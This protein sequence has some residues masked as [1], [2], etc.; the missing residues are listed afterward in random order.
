MANGKPSPPRSGLIRTSGLSNVTVSV[1]PV[2]ADQAGAWLRD[3]NPQNRSIKKARVRLLEAELRE[4]RY[5]LNGE[6]VIFDENGKLVDGQHR[7]SAIANTGIT[8]DCVIVRG[9]DPR[10]RRTIDQGSIRTISDDLQM[11]GR[12]R[13]LGVGAAARIAHNYLTGAKIGSKVTKSA[14]HDFIDAND[15]LFAAAEMGMGSGI[16]F[17]PRY[18]SATVFLGT[19]APETREQGA[20]FVAGLDTGANFHLGDARLALRE[21]FSR[22]RLHDEKITPDWALSAT[23]RA[24]NAW[25]VNLPMEKLVL[26]ASTGNEYIPPDIIG[27]PRR[28]SGLEATQTASLTPV[29]RSRVLMAIEGRPAMPSGGPGGGSAEPAEPSDHA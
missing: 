12:G 22:K 6:S 5:Q 8:V 13:A 3:N 15:S 11:E 25:I 19:L 23:I 21:A 16:M 28:A 4:G 17:Q 26:Q 29:Q 1:E 27:G 9:V 7:L 2:T 14:L 10:A 18:I 24:W 20:D